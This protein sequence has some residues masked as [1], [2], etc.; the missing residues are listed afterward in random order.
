[1]PFDFFLV[2][3]AAVDLKKIKDCIG[4]PQADVDNPVLKAEQDAQVGLP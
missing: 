3:T 4:D 1:M 2:Y